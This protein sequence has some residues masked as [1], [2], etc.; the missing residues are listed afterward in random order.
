MQEFKRKYTSEKYCSGTTTSI[1]SNKEMNDIMKIVHAPEDSNILLKG[2]TKP[3]KNETKEQK[4]GFL[5]MLFGTLRTSLLGKFIIRERNCKSSA[6]KKE[7]GIVRV[8][9]GNK[10]ECDF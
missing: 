5:S 7:K 4:R 1:I 8:G 6:N 9:Y 2:V 3:I 10:K